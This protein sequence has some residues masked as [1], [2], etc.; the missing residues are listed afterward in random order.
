MPTPRAQ[1]A[2][3]RQPLPHPELVSQQTLRPGGQAGAGDHTG[4]RAH[5]CGAGFADEEVAKGHWEHGQEKRRGPRGRR[6]LHAGPVPIT[7]GV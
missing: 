2:V 7:R 4:P 6:R 3:G 1:R 5:R